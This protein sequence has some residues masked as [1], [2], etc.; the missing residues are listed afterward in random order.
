MSKDQQTTE[1][2]DVKPPPRFGHDAKLEKKVT[3]RL[4]NLGEEVNCEELLDLITWDHYDNVSGWEDASPN[5]RY[6]LP[7]RRRRPH[8]SSQEENTSSPYYS[9]HQAKNDWRRGDGN[10]KKRCYELDFVDSPAWKICIEP[11]TY[12]YI[13]NN[14][15]YR[16]SKLVKKLEI[17][18]CVRKTCNEKLSPEQRQ[19]QRDIQRE[20]RREFETYLRMEKQRQIS[21]NLQK[22]VKSSEHDS[23]L[24]DDS[25]IENPSDGYHADIYE[26]N[27]TPVESISS[28]QSTVQDEH[29]PSPKSDRSNVKYTLSVHKPHHSSE[30]SLELPPIKVPLLRTTSDNHVKRPSGHSISNS[31]PL[32]PKNKV[33]QKAKFVIEGQMM[34]SDS[35]SGVPKTRRSMSE[36]PPHPVQTKVT[37]TSRHDNHS[38]SDQVC[39]SEPQTHRHAVDFHDSPIKLGYTQSMCDIRHPT[40]SIP[41]KVETLNHDMIQ[42]KPISTGHVSRNKLDSEEHNHWNEV[43]TASSYHPT[44]AMTHSTVSSAPVH[45]S[46]NKLEPDS[47]Q[48][49]SLEM[50]ILTSKYS[51]PK[52]YI[53]YR[54]SL[55]TNKK[56]GR[57]KPKP[58]HGLKTP[59]EPDVSDVVPAVI[60]VP[61][62]FHSVPINKV[63]PRSKKAQPPSPPGLLPEISG[64]RIPVSL[65]SQKFM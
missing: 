10:Q 25:D 16:A 24:D 9:S 62:A 11:T 34:E 32:M 23:V 37:R 36:P 13:P 63:R 7:T 47:N 29:T 38:V 2:V 51:S 56:S 50:G 60:P 19:L 14:G 5:V 58:T 43:D 44:A 4:L 31:T 42:V 30:P 20:L 55:G 39:Q 28:G 45:P 48:T 21:S 33:F 53:P 41:S 65:T 6:N 17:Q 22:Q 40:H 35:E 3:D 57:L 54:A 12:R 59:H 61:Q 46:R 18:K 64:H 52:S 8:A 27:S 15:R 26:H 49:G 1:D